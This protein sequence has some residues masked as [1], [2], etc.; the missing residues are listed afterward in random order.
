MNFSR[1]CVTFL[2]IFLFIS[3]I[4]YFLSLP[5]SRL[6]LHQLFPRQHRCLIEGRYII[7][8]SLSACSGSHSL[9]HVSP[10][11]DPVASE[12][13]SLPK[14]VAVAIVIVVTPPPR[15]LSNSYYPQILQRRCH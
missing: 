3:C 8:I 4:F 10:T 9:D 5:V 2:F 12:P 14:Q 15:R 11:L 1:F 7:S 6:L 13:V